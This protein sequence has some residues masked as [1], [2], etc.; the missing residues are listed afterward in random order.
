MAYMERL[1]DSKCI[2]LPLSVKRGIKHI[3]FED[4]TPLLGDGASRCFESCLQFQALQ[5]S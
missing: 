4:D 1:G 5:S 2:S 3:S